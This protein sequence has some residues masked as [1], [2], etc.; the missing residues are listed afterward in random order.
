MSEVMSLTAEPI[1]LFKEWLTEAE[2]KESNNPT[3]MSL[4]TA[5]AKGMPSV[6]MVLLKDVDERGFVFYTN[7]ESRKGSEIAANPNASLCFHWKSLLKVVR[8]D[9]AVEKVSDADADAY[10]NSRSR[11]SQIGAWASRQSRPLEN[12]FELEKQI[13]AYTAKFHIGKVPRPDFWKGYRVVPRRIEFWAERTFRLHDRIVY[14][15]EENGN[16][17][18]QRLYP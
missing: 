17:M 18:S 7:S 6:R 12:R 4:A 3:A 8:V 1:A 16:W 10:F 15:I 5:D 13:A 11:G 2:K 14:T 9:G